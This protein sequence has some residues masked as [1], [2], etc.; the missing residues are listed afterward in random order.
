MRASQ[1]LTTAL[2]YPTLLVTQ[3]FKAMRSLWGSLRMSNSALVN[4]T[5]RETL[6]K[7]GFRGQESGIPH[8]KESG[9][10][11]ALLLPDEPYNR[12][13]HSHVDRQ[14]HISVSTPSIF[15]LEAE[16]RH[17]AV[18]L[19]NSSVLLCRSHVARVLRQT[20]L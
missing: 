8:Q 9:K 7:Y 4:N 17:A 3:L 11:Q 18:K 12:R 13:H 20:H 14:K 1:T 2:K 19:I 6:T 5:K 10:W 16:P 15:M